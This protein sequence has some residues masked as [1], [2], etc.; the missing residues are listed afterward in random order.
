MEIKQKVMVDV[1]CW[2]PSR[3]W[4]IQTVISPDRTGYHRIKGL[5]NSEQWLTL[6]YHK[7]HSKLVLESHGI[8][9]LPRD[10][11]IFDKCCHQSGLILKIRVH[12]QELTLSVLGSAVN[13]LNKILKQYHTLAW[14]TPK[15]SGTPHNAM[16]W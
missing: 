4:F 2:K 16:E 14:W 1:C 3:L 11:S 5:H 9:G 12:S 10:W 6:I 8:E 15:Y 7:H 13:L